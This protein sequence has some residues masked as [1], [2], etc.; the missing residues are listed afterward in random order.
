MKKSLIVGIFSAKG[1]VGKSLIASNL[2]AV[3]ATTQQ[4]P[5]LLVD[6]S[7]GLGC[8]DL[9]LDVT[10]ERTWADLLPVMDELMPQHLDLAV[11][12]H[13]SG[14]HL[15]ACPEVP[16][17]QAEFT[18]PALEALLAAL[19]Q[20]YALIVLD[21][22]AG[23]GVINVSA[24]HLAD[25]RLVL[26]TAD[27]P[28]LRATQRYLGCL[29]RGEKPIGLVLNQYG[30]G[31]PVSPREIGEH[32]DGPLY[33]ILPVDASAAWANIGYGQP[34]ALKQKRGLGAALRG[35]AKTIL[36]TAKRAGLWETNTLPE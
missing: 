4:I 8:A 10:A 17:A 14:L 27:A 29:A 30:R 7:A 15:L 28:A 16:D 3:F 13:A 19:R 11:T 21:V 34:C 20:E 33:A 25:L 12:R 6:L 26:L 32:L 23:M 1:G 2:G 35:L 22:P 24:F 9:L 36:K 31:A 5:T 18:R